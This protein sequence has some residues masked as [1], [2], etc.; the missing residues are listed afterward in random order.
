MNARAPRTAPWPGL[1]PPTRNGSAGDGPSTSGR[2]PEPPRHC[3]VRK[4]R[5]GGRK[6]H[7]GAAMGARGL[8]PG[9]TWAWLA[10]TVPLTRAPHTP[11]TRN[12]SAGDGPSTSGRRPEP[13]R[14]AVVRKRRAGGSPSGALP[15]EPAASAPGGR[16]PG[17]RLQPRFPGKSKE[18]HS[19]F[20]FLLERQALSHGTHCHMLY[21]IRPFFALPCHSRYQWLTVLCASLSRSVPLPERS[22]SVRVTLGSP[23]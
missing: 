22:F 3:V 21:P 8:S 5:A 9:R 14:H 10:R 16:R 1:P 20:P 17:V 13:P 15:W 7:P 23:N 19:I 4:R 11:P 18:A 2:R 12:G 6:P